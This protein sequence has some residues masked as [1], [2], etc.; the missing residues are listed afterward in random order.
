MKRKTKIL[1]GALIGFTIIIQSWKN[2]RGEES[3]AIEK[4]V[5]TLNKEC[6]VQLDENTILFR[7]NYLAPDTMVLNYQMSNVLKDSL[8]IEATKQT[9]EPILRKDIGQKI[10]PKTMLFSTF[11][12]VYRYYDLNQEF[13]FEIVISMQ[14]SPPNDSLGALHRFRR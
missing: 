2:F 10:D 5:R 11:N 3:I 8:D 14:K 9:F 6:P 12:S 13:L 1:I 7:Y 4:I